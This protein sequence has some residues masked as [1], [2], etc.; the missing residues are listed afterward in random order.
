MEY[1]FYNKALELVDVVDTV[2]DFFE[3]NG[4]QASL[5]KDNDF[6]YIIVSKNLQD[7]LFPRIVVKVC[8]ENDFL[9]VRFLNSDRLNSKMFLSSIFGFFGGNL[10]LLN[11][12]V[13][14]EKIERLEE[15]FWKYI[16][17]NL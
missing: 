4:F 8:K 17:S 14:K 11:K 3:R 12:S 1:R 2:R 5:I 6:S 9:S 13:V 10:F 15:A 7:N 16:E